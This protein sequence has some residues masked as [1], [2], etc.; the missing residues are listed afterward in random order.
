MPDARDLARLPEPELELALREVGRA[1]AWPV[2]ATAASDDAA[3]RAR[4]RIVE[5]GIRPARRSWP[6]WPGRR[7]VGSSLGIAVAALLVIAAIAA[8]IGL[9][10][11]GIRIT[12]TSSPI[13]TAAPSAT[14]RIVV[15]GASATPSPTPGPLGWTL[16]L[17]DPFSVDLARK[18]VS[19]PVRLPPERYGAPASAWFLDGRVSFVWPSGDGLLPLE[20]R[21]L[22]L[23][24]T[25]MEGGL[26]EGYFDKVLGPGTTIETVRVDGTTGYWITGR[27]H[28]L[29]YVDPH[30]EPVFDTRRVVGDTLIWARDGITYRLEVNLGREAAIE[31]AGSLR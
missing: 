13:P 25:E 3:A 18:A 15:P 2:A 23:V 30:G 5:A 1:L 28:E 9:G 8:A 4:R 26:D 14:P 10:L 29:I 17:G 7:P 6:A 24:L 12:T 11:P 31:L 16:G 20:E 19:F 21:D 22:G 27:P